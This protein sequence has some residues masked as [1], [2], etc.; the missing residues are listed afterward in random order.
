MTF[1]FVTYFINIKCRNGAGTYLANC[2]AIGIGYFFT[3]TMASG[4]SCGFLNPM[5][6]LVELPFAQIYN[7][8]IYAGNPIQDG[9]A[10]MFSLTGNPN[11]AKAYAIYILAPV[12]GGLIA[13]LFQR[14]V[15]DVFY[16]RQ[17][18]AQ[19]EFKKR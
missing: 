16:Y 4:I 2:V 7:N 15:V 1:V 13:G 6:G 3:V 12:A 5:I 11:N 14:F 18:E 10:P 19:E 8:L 17:H 9:S